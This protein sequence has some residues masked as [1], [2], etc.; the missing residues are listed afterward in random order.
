LAVGA[1]GRTVNGVANAGAVFVFKSGTS[2]LTT[3]GVQQWNLSIPSLGQAVRSGDNFGDCLAAGDFNGDG[4]DDL[5]ITV[6]RR[7]L[8][9]VS[10]IDQGEV[11]VASGSSAGLST[12][13]VLVLNENTPGLP[14]GPAVNGD[15]FGSIAKPG[16]FNGDSYDDLSISTAGKTVSGLAHAGAVYL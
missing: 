4:K 13:G 12:G 14:N 15:Q 3:T 9:G 10:G 6:D 7:D 2:G 16:N 8:K 11:L 1:D 5:A